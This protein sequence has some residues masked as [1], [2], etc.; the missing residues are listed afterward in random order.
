MGAR[1]HA[2]THA[3]SHTYTLTDRSG[4]NIR[5]IFFIT[6]YDMLG[7]NEQFFRKSGRSHLQTRPQVAD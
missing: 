6:K 7:E 5:S 1:T 3:L 4:N 2:R